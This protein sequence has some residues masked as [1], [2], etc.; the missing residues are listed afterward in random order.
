MRTPGKTDINRRQFLGLTTAGLAGGW[1]SRR[2]GALSLD[3]ADSWDPAMPLINPAR[4]LKV[5][6]VL[7][8]VLPK[9]RDESSWKS[10]GG[11]QTESAAAEETA[12]I[13]GEL[14]RLKEAE[15]PLEISSVLKVNTIEQAARLRELDHD[16][17]L[18]YACTGS[19]ELLKTCLGSKPDALIFVRHRSGPIYYWY[20]ALSVR[21]LDRSDPGQSPE[22]GKFSAHVDD[23]VV[24]DYRELAWRL[25]AL[26]AVANLRAT[27]IVALGGA[28]GKYSPE[29][30]QYARDKFGL[31][32]IEVSYDDLTKR[33]DRARADRGVRAAAE[34]SADHYLAMPGTSLETEKSYVTNAFLLHRMF[35]EMM[36]EHGAAAFTVKSC[37]GTIIPISQTTACLSLSLLSDEGWLAFCESDFVIIP[38]GILLRYISG[39]PVFLHNSTFPHQGIATCAHCTSP[40]RMNG[41][42]YEPA[43][44]MTHYESEYGAAPKVTMPVDQLLTILNPEYSAGRW[45]GFR[46]V[47]RDNPFYEICRSQQDVEIQGEWKRLIREVRDSH[48]VSAYGDFLD[49]AGFAA[50]KLGIQWESLAKG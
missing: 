23:V 6:P 39:R 25:R 34:K 10:W 20:E 48:W 44:I 36:V 24:D 38:A 22:A 1:L 13:E 41:R 17:T 45:L 31:K 19:G 29:A 5:Q 12:R 46:G 49:E 3:V 40:R 50:R 11:V 43:R 18:V 37:M 47:V 15:I 14:A 35:R 2:C 7:M 8:Y 4:K 21:Y 32:I 27:R 33:M 9:R 30:P 42:S 16:V 28:W 26:S